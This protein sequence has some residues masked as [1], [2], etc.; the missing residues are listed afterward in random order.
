MRAENWCDLPNSGRRYLTI[1]AATEVVEE[2]SHYMGETAAAFS[3]IKRQISGIDKGV[4]EVASRS[5][6]QS[7]TIKELN[8]AIM[9]I[10]QE[11]L[12]NASF[13]DNAR[14]VSRALTEQSE[15]L[16]ML[17]GGFALDAAATAPDL[18]A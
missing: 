4:F 7:A 9:S 8:F 5:M 1:D 18:A 13:A 16:V 14:E 2:G 3:S 17:V 15:R 11:T 10:D 6:A 12:Q